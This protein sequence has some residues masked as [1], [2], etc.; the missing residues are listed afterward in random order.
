MTLKR[1]ALITMCVML[2]ATIAMGIVV[3]VRVSPLVNALMGGGVSFGGQPGS[4]GSSEE[5]S[6]QTPPSSSEVPPSQDDHEHAFF[7]SSSHAAT[8]DSAGYSIYACACGETEMRDHVK[9]LG[10]SYGAGKLIAATCEKGGYTLRTCSVCRHEERRDLVD[11]LGHNFVTV[12]E[13]EA[14]CTERSYVKMQCDRAGCNETRENYGATPA[15]HDYQK[16]DPVAPSCEEDGYTPLKCSKCDDVVKSEPVIPMLGHSG[17]WVITR[18]PAAG[19]PGEESRTCT[20]C[21]ETQTRACAMTMVDT[22]PDEQAD[23]RLYTVQITAKDSQGQDVTVYTYTI[24]DYAMAG[25]VDFT[26][27]EE[28]GL[29]V[30]VTIDGQTETYPLKPGNGTLTLPAQ[31]ET[32]E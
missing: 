16:Q 26:Y 1:I 10:H 18:E 17:E 13:R 19:D 12:E 24:L 14:T 32:E 20:T 3:L 15:G 27:E 2:T 9:A 25:Q 29:L 7:W 30:K 31:T 28:T 23:H 4:S 21:G 6:S 11:P 8:C 5:P 22:G